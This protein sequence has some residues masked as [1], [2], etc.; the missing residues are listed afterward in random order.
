MMTLGR[1]HKT[2]MPWDPVSLFRHADAVTK[3]TQTALLLAGACCRDGT[4]FVGHFTNNS[5]TR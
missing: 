5:Q 3:I 1:T 4:R 2:V